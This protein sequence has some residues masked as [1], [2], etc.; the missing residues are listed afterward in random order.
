MLSRYCDLLLGLRFYH[1]VT[2][3]EPVRHSLFGLT[4]M[5][6]ALL[7]AVCTVEHIGSLYIAVG[8]CTELI[9]RKMIEQ[10][11]CLK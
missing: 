9:V 3:D 2:S 11:E 4:N 7:H 6:H 5:L 10:I 1:L 8:I